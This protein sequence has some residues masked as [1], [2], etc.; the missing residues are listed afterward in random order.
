MKVLVI[1]II[2]LMGKEVFIDPSIFLRTFED[3]IKEN[4]LIDGLTIVK[5][6][7]ELDDLTKYRNDE[8]KRD[9]KARLRRSKNITK[10]SLGDPNE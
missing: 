7:Q 6:K 8:Q 2:D 3:D 9:E 5:I 4:Y 1:K 10:V